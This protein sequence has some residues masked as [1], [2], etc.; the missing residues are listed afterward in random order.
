MWKVWILIALIWP[1]AVFGQ[2]DSSFSNLWKQEGWTNTNFDKKTV[3][4]GEI[5]SGGPP[6]DGIPPIY[7]PSFQTVKETLGMAS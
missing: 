2:A 5:I 1:L 6:R 7:E 3:P 4:F